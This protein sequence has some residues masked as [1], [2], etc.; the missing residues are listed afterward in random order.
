M[1]NK[2]VLIGIGVVA[3]IVG[4]FLLLRRNLKKKDEEVRENIK[5]SQEPI[6][7]LDAP[8]PD[9]GSIPPPAIPALNPLQAVASFL[10][11]WN[12]Y[13]VNTKT[14]GL[15]VRKNPDSKSGILLSLPKGST[16][17]GKASGV[18][19]WFAVS[20]DGVNTLGYVSS[21]LLKKA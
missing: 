16:I 20:K 5:G 21:D 7:G 18:K 13:V 15:N 10:T 19:G 2:N 3:A 1:K 14:R 11:N 8:T 4:G 17:K 6:A 12:D 9:S